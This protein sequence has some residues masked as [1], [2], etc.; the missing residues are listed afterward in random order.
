LEAVGSELVEEYL[1][2]RVQLSGGH[3]EFS[4]EAVDAILLEQDEVI[5]K[6]IDEELHCINDVAEKGMDYLERA[7]TEWGEP[8][9]DEWPRERLAMYLF[10]R[11]REAFGT[12]YDWYLWRTVANNMSHHQFTGV[13]AV[14]DAAHVDAL[15]ASIREY[16]GQQA[17][18]HACRVRHYQ[19]DDDSHII[20]V[21]RGDYLRTQPV[22]DHDDVTTTVFRPAKEDVL[23][24]SLQNSV[25]SLKTSSRSREER[26]NYVRAF[27]HCILDL[28]EIDPDVLESTAVSLEPI[29]N[30]SFNYWGNEQIEWVNLTE[31]QMFVSGSRE[32]KIKLNS[33][34]LVTV[35]HNDLP[36]LNFMNG[37][38]QSAKLKFKLCCDGASAKP[39]TVEIR[40]PGH[41]NLNKKREV[42][43][44]EA[45]LRQN[46]V[47]LV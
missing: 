42:D 14:F 24:F 18:G 44:V 27:G 10:L 9:G 38:L 30:G 8:F 6:R 22:W 33:S 39:L 36:A 23:C 32:I 34:D 46:G 16:Y 43:I 25:L 1:A 2:E 13:Q 29:Q 35:I 40:P 17:K 37:T 28:A 26:E 5:R 21:A 20:L 15:R 41:T 11:N 45:Y 47:L 3:D 31:V 19:N 7:C 4:D 12:A